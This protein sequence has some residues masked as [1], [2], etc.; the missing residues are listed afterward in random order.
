MLIRNIIIENKNTLLA[1]SSRCVSI[2]FQ[3]LIMRKLSLILGI[4]GYAIY[5]YYF[6]IFSLCAQLDFGL[7]LYTQNRISSN[8]MLQDKIDAIK[9]D[10]LNLVLFL[11]PGLFIVGTIVFF[12][13]DL[14]I[15]FFSFLF[16]LF[17]ALAYPISIIFSRTTFSFGNGEFF[18]YS[19]VLLLILFYIVLVM[20]YLLNIRIHN[21]LYLVTIY[22]TICLVLNFTV[23]YFKGIRLENVVF[24]IDLYSIKKQLKKSFHFW[25]YGLIGL[26]ITQFD[27]ILLGFFDNLQILAYY[28]VVTKIF[29]GSCFAIVSIILSINHPEITYNWSMNNIYYIKIIM[30][31]SLFKTMGI[32]IAFICFFHFF[33]IELISLFLAKNIEVSYFKDWIF[34]YYIFFIVRVLSDTLLMFLLAI[35]E[36]KIVNYITIFQ[37]ILAFILQIFL[38]KLYGIIGIITSLTVCYMFSLSL[39][40]YYYKKLRKINEKK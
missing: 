10:I 24:N 5:V 40:F 14:N 19:Q 13:I 2:I 16:F 30:Q 8:K 26:L 36:I 17:I 33:K 4:D 38:Y 1:I 9:K 25:L 12:F 28:S 15:S 35:S 27:I 32:T 31:R 6:T 23:S 22:Y 29:F 21:I 39:Y 18:Y 11:Y 7:A 3:L 20:N 34:Y 37:A